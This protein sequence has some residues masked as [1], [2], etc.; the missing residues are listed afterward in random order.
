MYTKKSKKIT[1]ISWRFS[2][3]GFCI[4]DCTVYSVQFTAIEY[5]LK[6][7]AVPAEVNKTWEITTTTDDLRIKCNGVE[8]NT[9]SIAK[10]MIITAL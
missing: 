3:W 7:T 2:D 4:S 5:S 10:H 8:V 6:L 1:D 9:L